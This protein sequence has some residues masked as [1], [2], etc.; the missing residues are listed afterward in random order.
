MA[1]ESIL[2]LPYTILFLIVFCFGIII[3]SFL[4]V[5]ILRLPKGESL[6]KR[7]SHCMT[8]GEKIKVRDLVP[9]F[10]WLFLRGKCRNCGEKI[11]SRYP[12]VEALNGIMWVLA[13]VKFDFTITAVLYALLF[14]ALIVVGFMDWDT[15]EINLGVLAFIGIL[16][17]G[18]I[19][20]LKDVTLASHLIGAVAISIPFLIIALITKGI[21]IGDVLLMAGAGL[22]LGL[23][24]I[25]VAAFV[26]IILAC[27]VGLIIKLVKK[28]SRFAFGPWLSVGIA[29]SAFF[30]TTIANFYINLIK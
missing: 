7:S 22:F 6:I 16:G 1:D 11:S 12:I 4:N 29:F 27:A 9:L 26:G 15:Q 5:C 14:S 17:V 28:Q 20:L 30:G 18:A 13:F 23:K 24:G 3:G 21:G 19:F 10:S 8:C 25:L 2:I